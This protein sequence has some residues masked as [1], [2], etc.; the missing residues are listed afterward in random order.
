MCRSLGDIKWYDPV[1]ALS[2]FLT[3]IIM[4]LTY[5]IAYGLIA[6][7]MFWFSMQALFKLLDL[8]GIQRRMPSREERE[9]SSLTGYGT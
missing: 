1:H 3:V 7:M 2:A 9:S 8:M 4:P 6:G 5:S